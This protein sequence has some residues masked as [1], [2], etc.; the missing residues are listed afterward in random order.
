MPWSGAKPFRK[1]STHKTNTFFDLY[2]SGYV[3]KVVGTTSSDSLRIMH[4]MNIDPFG[5]L[6][7]QESRPDVFHLT[8]S[9]GFWAF[10][11]S[12]WVWQVR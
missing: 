12:V 10:L 3:P 2:A 8:I 4:N 5:C 1:S 6:L 9:K 7:C 11:D